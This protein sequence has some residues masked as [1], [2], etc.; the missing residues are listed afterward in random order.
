LIYN[1]ITFEN[2]PTTCWLDKEWVK[3][4]REQ[5]QKEDFLMIEDCFYRASTKRKAQIMGVCVGYYYQLRSKFKIKE[6][7]A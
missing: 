5:K 6:I 7:S 3:D 2:W 4:Q 1:S